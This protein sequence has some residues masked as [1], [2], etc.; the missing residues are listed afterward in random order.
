LAART[1]TFSYLAGLLVL[2][3]GCLPALA[4]SPWTVQQIFGKDAAPGPPPPAN[5]SWSPDGAR[6]TY[7][8]DRGDLVSIDAT[9][10]SHSVLIPAQK[11]TP[12]AT[13][14]VS[15]KDADHRNRYSQPAYFWS[16]DAS[17]ILF[18]QDGTLW[19][20]TLA[21]H[22]MR[23]IGDSRQGSG[24][25]AKFSPDGTTISYLHNGNIYSVSTADP[26]G[27]QPRALTH[28]TDPALLNGGVDWVY[29]EELAAR[30]NYSWSPDSAHLEYIQMDEH[31]VPEYP[32]TDWIPTHA[33]LDMQRYPQAGDPN[34]S[35]RLGVV[36][37]AGGETRWI[38]LP[39][40]S[41][42]DYIPR[43]GWVDAHTV[44]IETVTRDQKHLNLYFANIGSG[45][46]KLVL[47]L[48]DPKFFE[49]YEMSFYAPGAFLLTSWR[50]GFT[51]IY[52]YTYSP[53]EPLAAEARLECE[54][55]QGSYEVDK[56]LSV[57]NAA[58]TV[59]Y[60][61]TETPAGPD[62]RQKQLWSVSL[63][64]TAK[65]IVSTTPGNHKPQFADGHSTYTE[66]AS[67]VT[68]PPS[69]H[70]CAI[71]G[72]CRTLWQQAADTRH[73][74][75]PPIM[76]ELKAA[77]GVTTLYASLTL[78]QSGTAP[79]SF[80]LINNPYGGPAG[81]TTT[82]KWGGTAYSFD[83]LMAEHGFA[84]LHVDNR[85]MGARGRDFEQAAYLDFGGVQL[86]DQL[87]A[88]DQVLARYPQLDSRRLGW[89]GWSWGGTFTLNA[90]THSDRFRAGVAVAPVTDFRNYDSIYTERYLGLPA[91]Q[92]KIY[93]AAAI[94]P[95]ASH[96]KGHLLLV[97]GT[98]DDNVHIANSIE[99]IQR[100]IDANIPYDLQLYPRK[101]HS[102]AGPEARIHLYGRIVAHFERYLKPETPAP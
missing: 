73:T 65:H 44:W 63:D 76:L 49:S 43:H 60:T 25:D 20:Y 5:T 92:P 50:D 88:I 34:P 46:V 53:T 94:L 2:S 64:G 83:E 67:N 29:L 81:S 62:P 51:H 38:D 7:I 17:H 21:S 99:F 79:A 24:D 3:L 30:T 55:E 41:G 40:H 39:I 45:Q 66:V 14:A 57:D 48:S 80:P 97:H 19:L 33:T 89:W 59:Y 82:D 18:D 68:I 95:V 61:S 10:G 37:A 9:T 93:D 85:G 8:S 56:I 47:A 71:G 35:V 26:A 100:L 91:A 78:P 87:A 36:A 52:R 54:L 102:I 13:H 72:A 77:D 31:A 42:D 27:D 86:A 28:S 98:G 32:L 75:N 12:V 11:L 74:A 96:L 6:F 1:L 4:S 84:M 69:L 101:T 90:L 70:L 16:P 15:E 58:H 23:Q 22:S